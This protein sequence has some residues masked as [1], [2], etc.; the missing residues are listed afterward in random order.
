MCNLKKG[1]GTKSWKRR[2][3][4]HWPS[5][6]RVATNW[7]STFSY[8]FNIDPT[9]FGPKTFGAFWDIRRWLRKIPTF[10]MCQHQNRCKKIWEKDGKGRLQSDGRSNSWSS[11]SQQKLSEKL[12]KNLQYFSLLDAACEPKK[13]GGFDGQ[14]HGQWLV[15]VPRASWYWSISLWTRCSTGLWPG[16]L[17]HNLH[18]RWSNHDVS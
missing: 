7:N 15:L 12:G 11:C 13:S 2:G 14:I 6:R 3:V 1:F 17:T 18:F 10:E 8:I 4:C 16:D 9:F 5:T